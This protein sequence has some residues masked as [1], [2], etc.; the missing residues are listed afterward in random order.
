MNKYILLFLIISFCFSCKEK[1]TN[2]EDSAPIQNRNADFGELYQYYH[3][4]PTTLEQKEENIIIEYAADNNLEAVRTTSG[5]YISNHIVGNGDLVK[6]GDPITVHYRGYF[7]NGQEF[8]SS[9]KKGQPI[10]FRVGSMVAGWNEAIPYLNI[11]SKATFL[12]PSHMGYGKRGFPGYV[13]PDKIL[14]FDIEILTKG[15]ENK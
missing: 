15:N 4:N 1:K 11:G 13:D 9:I 7:M 2:V 6:W 10:S 12:I 3:T 5:V 8:D 14:I